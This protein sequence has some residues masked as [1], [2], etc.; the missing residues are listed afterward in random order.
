VRSTG[1]L[2]LGVACV[3]AMGIGATPAR[4]MHA[5]HPT[6]APDPAPYTGSSGIAGRAELPTELRTELR[7][8][9]RAELRVELRG[10]RPPLV[11]QRLEW[12]KGGLR[13]FGGGAGGATTSVL[14][15]WDEVRTVTGRPLTEEERAF[16]AMA[17]DLWRARQRVQRGD[18]ELAAELFE[19]HA[20]ALRGTTSET[21][22]IVAEGILR[23]R[24]A[25]SPLQ[26]LLPA[27][28]V[29][30]LRRAAIVSDRYAGLPAVLDE[31]TLLAPSLGAA[32]I[33][34]PSGAPAIA[35]EAE[36]EAIAGEID[37]LLASTT[38]DGET[39]RVA[40]LLAA[41][42]RRKPLPAGKREEGAA[43]L[44]AAMMEL[45]RIAPNDPPEAKAR[46]RSAAL[47]STKGLGPWANA[48]ARLAIGRSLVAETVASEREQGVLMLL[49][50]PAGRGAV[51]EQESQTAAGAQAPLAIVRASLEL[52][53]STL[54]S[55][56][57]AES[58]AIVERELAAHGGGTRARGGRP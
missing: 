40:E 3:I 19:R 14:L 25:R 56:G 42:L 49:A 34:G 9:L 12:E 35:A 37:L 23:C 27:L 48:W 24:I 22:L 38:L 1:W 4:A 43:G 30:R 57:D 15:A 33:L 29:A 52:A 26:A 7:S 5:V 10:A 8:E 51:M 11:A 36:R 53:A 39:R 50:I 28:E 54:R 13:V 17:E 41:I 32:L 6:L 21:A 46:A 55:L 20:A 16:L 44:L 31:Q 18:L 2:D 47:S 45:D 58:A